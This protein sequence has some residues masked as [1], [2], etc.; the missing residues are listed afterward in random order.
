MLEAMMNQSS[1]RAWGSLIVMLAL[2]LTSACATTPAISSAALVGM[3]RQEDAECG[4]ALSIRELEFHSDGSFSVTW[5][6]F[7]T[8][9]DYWGRWRLDEAGRTLHLT[10]E[11]ANYT[12]TD[13]AGDGRITLSDVVLDLGDISLGSPRHGQRCLAAFRRLPSP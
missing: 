8:Y 9:H 10:I 1:R 7:E 3:W 12:P 6:P 2:G 13:F 5:R 11:R 4:M